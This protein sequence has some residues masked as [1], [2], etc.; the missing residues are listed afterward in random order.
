MTTRGHDIQQ[1]GYWERIWRR[2]NANAFG[3]SALRVIVALFVLAALAPFLANSHALV[4]FNQGR[5]EF[6]IF[7]S[8]E[9]IEWRFLVYVPLAGVV[10]LGRKW[11][12]RWPR[13]DLGLLVLL[14]L[15]AGG[16]AMILPG[17]ITLNPAALVANSHRFALTFAVPRV[18]WPILCFGALLVIVSFRPRAWFRLPTANLTSV[19]FAVLLVESVLSG[20]HPLNNPTN[21][22]DF[23]GFK[24][25]P[26]IPYSPNESSADQF[27]PPSWKHWCG[28]DYTGRDI[29]ARMVHGART[30][31]SIGFVAQSIALLVGV[32]IGG[33]AGYYRGWTDVAICRFI[34]VLDC[35]PPLLLILVVIG[36]F[37]SQNNMFVIMAVIG[38][39]SWTG[40]ARLVRG[41]FLRL[42]GQP[43]PQAAKA[44]GAGDAHIILRHLLPNA[45]GPILVSATFGVASAI[46]IESSLSFLGFGM[47][48]PTS[49]WGD[50]LSDARLYIEFA[51]W[52]AFFPGL[53]ILI[54]I[55]SYNFVGEALRDA[56][57]PRLKLK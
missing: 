44:L 37:D 30:S 6:P 51:W 14:L 49:S 41:E 19:I 15:A 21:D 1:E 17:Q 54:T 3:R 9:P 4:R 13:L 42:V 55:M 48:A 47:Q 52:L 46:L 43:F 5:P 26:P 56:V 18:V 25:M 36:V 27:A 53:A 23:T 2:F 29:A 39:T 45:L 32:T 24:I 57:D 16:L 34:E 10:F 28:T 20:L 11:L 35:F 31:L 8:L 33:L 22:R 50:I 38:L 12:F 40:L 7:P